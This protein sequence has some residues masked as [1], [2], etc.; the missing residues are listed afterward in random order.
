M[1]PY[2][3]QYLSKLSPRDP[4]HL[5]RRLHLMGGDDTQAYYSGGGGII[6]SH[7]ALLR[8]GTAYVTLMSYI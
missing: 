1:F 6:L 7:E 5:G 3:R 4:I 8:L 2:L